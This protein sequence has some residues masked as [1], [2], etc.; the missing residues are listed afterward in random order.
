MHFIFIFISGT[1]PVVPFIPTLAKELGFSS[2]IVG[3]VYTFLPI[4]GMIAKPSMGALADRFHCQKIIFLLFIVLVMVFFI[5][6]PFIPPLPSDSK[7]N[8]HCNLDS[9]VQIC[10]ESLSD[11]CYLKKITDFGSENSTIKCTVSC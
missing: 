10:S 5:F 8:I 2:F 6:I 11:N 7:A 9:V 3:I 4:M 1:A